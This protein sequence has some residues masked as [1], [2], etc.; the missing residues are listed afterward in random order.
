[1][2]QPLSSRLT[3]RVCSRDD[4]RGRKPALPGTSTLHRGQGG[5]RGVSALLEVRSACWDARCISAQPFESHKTPT[6]AFAPGAER[7]CPPRPTPPALETDVPGRFRWTSSLS[8]GV[9][10]PTVAVAV[11]MN[12]GSHTPEGPAVRLG[13]MRR[14]EEDSHRA[15]ALRVRRRTDATAPGRVD[16][17]FDLRPDVARADRTHWAWWRTDS[18]PPGPRHS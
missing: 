1:M 6:E 16:C 12:G 4:P 14:R 11:M 17:Q 10:G 8:A 3:V 13:A 5:H 7:C 15:S 18:V 2:T 9:C